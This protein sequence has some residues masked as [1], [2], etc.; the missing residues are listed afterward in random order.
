MTLFTAMN[1]SRYWI[2][3]KYEEQFEKGENQKGLDKEYVRNWLRDNGFTGEGSIPDL[4]NDVIT[5]AS[6]NV[7]AAYEL[8][9][10]QNFVPS[11]I[12]SS[13]DRMQKNLDSYFK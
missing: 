2:Q 4:P 5:T 9:T 1:S 10:G 3:D 11:K 12:Y 7:I 8:I 13:N 6:L